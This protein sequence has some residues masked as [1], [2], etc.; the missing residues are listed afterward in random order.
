[1]LAFDIIRAAAR[2]SCMTVE[3][4]R[5]PKRNRRVMRTRFALYWVL[6]ERG[7]SFA[8]IGMWMSRDHS[9]VIYGQRRAADLIERDPSFREFCQT[10][11]D[12]RA[13]KIKLPE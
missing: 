4:L 11:R 10:L 3:Y 2:A 9:T 12:M 6:R 8:Q 5:G 13:E 7:A 1:M